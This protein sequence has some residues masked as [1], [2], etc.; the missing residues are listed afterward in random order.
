MPM[1]SQ[2]DTQVT[3]RLGENIL[4]AELMQAGLEVADP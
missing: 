1:T 2:L 3:E 4:V